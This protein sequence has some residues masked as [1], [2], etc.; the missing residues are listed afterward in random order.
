[1]YHL[2]HKIVTE[3]M[4]STKVTLNVYGKGLVI[5]WVMKGPILWDVWMFDIKLRRRFLFGRIA[6]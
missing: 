6:I 2:D 1:M 4:E 3:F 5:D